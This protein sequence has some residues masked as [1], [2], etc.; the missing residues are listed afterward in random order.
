MF[1]RSTPCDPYVKVLANGHEIFKT[2]V[3]RN[4]S[5]VQYVEGRISSKIHKNDAIVVEVWDENGDN[6]NDA[7]IYRMN[8]SIEKLL[9]DS[10]EYDYPNFVIVK[11]FWQ[12]ETTYN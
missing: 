8:T 4:K 9:S 6:S 7:L 12:D 5:F 2:T 3:K 1:G 11:G 10:D